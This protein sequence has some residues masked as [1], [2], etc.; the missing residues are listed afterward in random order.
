MQCWM[1]KYC[2]KIQGSVVTLPC[3]LAPV[4]D[5]TPGALLG[6][7]HLPPQISNLCI[8]KMS[9]KIIP[10]K[11]YPHDKTKSSISWKHFVSQ[12]AEMR[13]SGSTS[14]RSLLSIVAKN[15]FPGSD[16]AAW[17]NLSQ[18]QPIRKPRLL[19][20]N[21]KAKTI[22][23]TAMISCL[24]SRESP[25]EDLDFSRS[26]IW[27]GGGGKSIVY[28]G[29]FGRTIYSVQNCP[30]KRA[31]KFKEQAEILKGK[32]K[33]PSL[34]MELNAAPSLYGT[35]H[36][37]N[38]NYRDLPHLRG[39]EFGMRIKVP[40]RSIQKSLWKQLPGAALSLLSTCSLMNLVSKWLHW[41]FLLA[42]STLHV[43]K[44]FPIWF[45]LHNGFLLNPESSE[46][47]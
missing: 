34:V 4:L 42:L 1:Y 15:C 10:S 23:R 12:H 36:Q 31:D 9:I 3:G 26:R 46:F 29:I 2:S 22:Q 47:F 18:V 35:D 8:K 13:S 37:K 39:T 30:V 24:A 17:A 27:G 38:S 11:K 25:R 44:H 33:Q 6:Y 14:Q 45:W 32:L 43:V 21:K 7:P 28:N 16:F 40:A 5:L 19:P 20:I 41:A